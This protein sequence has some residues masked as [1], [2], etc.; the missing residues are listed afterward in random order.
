MYLIIIAQIIKVQLVK[1]PSVNVYNLN[2]IYN[3]IFTFYNAYDYISMDDMVVL[4]GWGAVQMK[5][6]S[7]GKYGLN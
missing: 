6:N 2:R 5:N 7:L 3:L 1:F 4:N